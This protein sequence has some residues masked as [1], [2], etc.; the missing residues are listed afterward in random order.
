MCFKTTRKPK[1]YFKNAIK[2]ILIIHPL[3]GGKQKE[4]WKKDQKKF[5]LVKKLFYFSFLTA[6]TGSDFWFFGCLEGSC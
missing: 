1:E 6:H 3:V 2:L 4:R 5:C